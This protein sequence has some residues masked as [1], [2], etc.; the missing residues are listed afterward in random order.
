MTKVGLLVIS[1]VLV[2]SILAVGCAKPEAE[3]EEAPATE[4]GW[5]TSILYGCASG[6]TTSSWYPAHAKMAELGE[7]GMG[8]SCTV[9]LPGGATASL[10]ATYDANQELGGGS[11]V[12]HYEMISGLGA[13]EGHPME[14]TLRAL[15][16]F[17]QNINSMAVRADS[18]VYDVRDLAGR[19]IFLGTPGATNYDQACLAFDALGIECDLFA[20]EVHDATVAFKDRRI[21]LFLKSVSGHEL[22]S[23]HVDIMATTPIRLIGYTDEEIEK[24]HEV[25]LRVPFQHFPAGWFN[26]LPEQGALNMVTFYN[27][28]VCR[29][30]FPEELAYRWTKT[31]IENF[32]EIVEVFF[33]SAAVDPLETPSVLLPG[34]YLHPGAIR[35]YREVGVNVPESVIP[36]EMK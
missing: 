11:T 32:G 29:K 20:G 2:V 30:D 9:T 1:A 18:D 4:A 36:P 13:W 31:N 16:I 22:D 15:H 5:P 17:A 28:I 33:G 24:V 12:S 7:R 23:S 14:N 25:Y 21:D 35:Y 26:P 27:D 34:C 3:P 10:Q 8:I 6:S 19:P